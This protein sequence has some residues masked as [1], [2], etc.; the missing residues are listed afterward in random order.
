M[1]DEN[2]ANRI[3]E[4]LFDAFPDKMMFDDL[5]NK[6]PEFRGLAEEEWF[7]ALEAL[8]AD[9]MIDGKFLR[10]GMFDTV[11]HA[12]LL[13]ISAKGRQQVLSIRAA[14]S[15]GKVSQ[16]KGNPSSQ[17]PKTKDLTFVTTFEKYTVRQAIG[18]GGAGTVYDVIDEDGK[19]FALK[20]LNH[21]ADT[22]KTKRFKNEISFCSRNIH[23]NVVRVLDHGAAISGEESR[24]F[25]VMPLY[26]STLRKLM[27]SN[28]TKD[29]E[30]MRLFGQILDGVEAAHLQSVVHR[31]LKPENI[32]FDS[33]DG[34][35]V[36]A[37]FGIARFKEEDLHTAVETHNR[38]RLANFL[39]SAPEQRERGKDIGCPAD[40][41]A[42]G[43]I[44]NELFTS[45]VP[46]GA[47]FK[48]IGE[49]SS[50]HAFLDALVDEMIQQDPTKRPDSIKT[51]KLQLISRGQNFVRLQELSRLK[52]TVLPETANDDPLITNPLKLVG[53]DYASGML[54]L[55]LSQAPNAAWIRVF[56]NLGNFAAVYGAEPSRFIFSADVATIPA[57]ENDAQIILNHFKNYLAETN[58]LY[59]LEIETAR[60]RQIEERDRE[61][62]ESVAR[63]EKE[64]KTREA[65]LKNIRI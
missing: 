27:T 46:Q 59:R 4:I 65:I 32:L 36:I 18:N 11:Q 12:T 16:A 64:K 38:E 19:H 51:I 2:L 30:R 33:S 42:L 6:L 22:T 10:T 5:R 50:D 45:Q 63:L 31:D 62:R 56:V 26:P 39:Y 1:Y 14:H 47:G 41:Y 54:E 48:R 9:G 8:R 17:A 37:D 49:V 52:D 35:V 20:L 15:T 58:R 53:V 55:A 28:A 29:A 7:R 3:L 24:P 34:T 40:V 60:Q 61:L 21:A 23:P 13:L 43:L 44:L 25:Y 57:S